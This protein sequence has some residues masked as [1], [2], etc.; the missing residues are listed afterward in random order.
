MRGGDIAIPAIRVGN[1]LQAVKRAAVLLPFQRIQHFGNQIVD[2]E[3]LE[4]GAS[5]MDRNRQAVRDVVAEGGN[6]AVV[7]RPAPLA[8]QVREPVNQY[9]R[10]GLSGISKEQLLARLLAP[11]VIAVISADQCGL[12]RGRQHHRT[13]VSVPFE[14]VQQCGGKAE[15][16]RHELALLPRTVDPGQV[17][18]KIGLGAE[19]V[20][21][22]GVGVHVIFQNFI[23]REPWAGPV[24]SVTDV[25][26]RTG[27]V[28]PDKSGR[29]GDQYV[30]IRP[31]F[32]SSSCM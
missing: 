5:I 22:R 24:L 23:N 18:H 15:V 10:A 6:R 20:Q 16:A 28:F 29:T 9:P 3:Q 19:L 1:N 31:S 12:N 30:H 7:V 21:Q 13:G 8:E 17:E 25:F 11:S 32:F 4:L 2:I 26:E 14:G 27:Q